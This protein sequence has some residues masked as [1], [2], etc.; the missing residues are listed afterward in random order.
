MKEANG[1]TAVKPIGEAKRGYVGARGKKGS[2]RIGEVGNWMRVEGVRM[3]TE[4][5]QDQGSVWRKA[6]QSRQAGQR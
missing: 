5:R 4:D 1:R 6:T 3:R 2:R